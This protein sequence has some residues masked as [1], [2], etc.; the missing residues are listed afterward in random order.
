M[1]LDTTTTPFIDREEVRGRTDHISNGLWSRIAAWLPNI[2]S[3]GSTPPPVQ[4]NYLTLIPLSDDR[5]KPRH[6]KA[7]ITAAII[8]A[9]LLATTVFVTVPRGVAV[10]AVKVG[11]SR[12]TLRPRA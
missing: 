7:L 4:S 8:F 11:R 3:R 10:G 5:L 1:P 2:P 12:P 6:D 9:A